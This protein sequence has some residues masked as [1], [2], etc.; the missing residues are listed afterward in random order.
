MSVPDNTMETF[1]R[2]SL[3]LLSIFY[4][5]ALPAIIK[6]LRGAR[7]AKHDRINKQ[8]EKDLR[9]DF[10]Y[11]MA[12]K[13]RAGIEEED[14]IICWDML[15]YSIHIARGGIH[16][17]GVGRMEIQRLI[18]LLEENIPWTGEQ[19]GTE[20]IDIEVLPDDLT[21][22]Q[23]VNQQHTCKTSCMLKELKGLMSDLDLN[24]FF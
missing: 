14:V 6:Q 18:A 12:L 20:L 15:L 19:I 9:I 4:I 1:G 24:G 10:V 11:N 7:K 23:L 8:A 2:I 5:A 21:A 22:F 17:R 16:D 13:R 3:I